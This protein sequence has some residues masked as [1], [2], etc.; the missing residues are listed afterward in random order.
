MLSCIRLDIS[1]W[2][3]FRSG[4]VLPPERLFEP[5][6]MGWAEATACLRARLRSGARRARGASSSSQ[7]ATR[8]IDA[9]FPVLVEVEAVSRDQVTSSPPEPCALRAEP[10]AAS[11]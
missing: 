7:V 4:A 6:L 10:P 3:R 9:D 5:K 2:C 8:V 1:V 11:A